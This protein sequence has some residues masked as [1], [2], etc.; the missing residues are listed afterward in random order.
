MG[1]RSLQNINAGHG[2]RD[3]RNGYP[4]FSQQNRPCLFA[5]AAASAFAVCIYDP[6]SRPHMTLQILQNYDIIYPKIPKGG[7]S[8]WS[9]L[10]VI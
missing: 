7:F 1:T 3:I 8:S 2:S 9:R 6:P 4:V 10:Y 5:A